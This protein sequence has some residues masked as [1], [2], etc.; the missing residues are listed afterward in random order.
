MSHANTQIN[1][2]SYAV[3]TV[4]SMP[5]TKKT[6]TATKT[7]KTRAEKKVV[8]EIFEKCANLTNDKYWISIFK[9][10][11]RDKFP[12]GFQYKNGLLIHRRGNK[13]TRI[14]IPESPTEASSICIS[15]FKQASGLMSA[16]DRRRIQKEEE[17]RLLEKI[18]SRE[19]TWK[20]I[21]AERVKELL[22]S[23]YISELSRASGF[24]NDQKKEL[25]TTIKKGFM[26]KYFQ[27]KHITMEHGKISSIQGLIFNKD[28]N[29]FYIDSR[30][31][32]K[33]PGRKVKGLGIERAPVKPKGTPIALWEKY[34]DNLEKKIHGKKSHNFQII[35]R[36]RSGSASYSGEF[37]S[38]VD[39]TSFSPIG[40]YSS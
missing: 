20:D 40:S 9:S 35:D 32:K 31:M 14:L 24:D 39:T 22:I 15:F 12:R 8:H 27:S 26:L 33:K 21:K 28:T 2:G 18:N 29:A 3:T 38:P 10:C 11:A 17:E 34:L 16:S 30:L 1:T 25:A 13:T 4:Y 19:M 23:E 5:W 6:S 37:S 7:T 36:T